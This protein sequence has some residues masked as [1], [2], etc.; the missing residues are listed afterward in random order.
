MTLNQSHLH[1]VHEFARFKVPKF[2]YLGISDE[3]G[4]V[5]CSTDISVVPYLPASDFKLYVRF[6]LIAR[7]VTHLEL[8]ELNVSIEV[9][10][11]KQGVFGSA[12]PRLEGFSPSNNPNHYRYVKP[13]P[14][15][16]VGSGVNQYQIKREMR[17]M[18]APGSHTKSEWREIMRRDGWKCLRCGSTKNLSKDHVVPIAGGGSNGADNLQ[19]LCTSCNS[20]K[21]ARSIDFRK[22]PEPIA[23]N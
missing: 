21:G 23:V 7:L 10:C 2:G 11:A 5:F 14:L 17:M 18:L 15:E 22:Q 9:E 6:G 4:E 8:G 1:P 13:A 12:I 19:T 3:G 20:W 16:V